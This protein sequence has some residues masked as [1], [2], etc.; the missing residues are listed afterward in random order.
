MIGGSHGAGIDRLPTGRSKGELIVLT[1][2][3]TRRF[4]PLDAAVSER[5]Q[6]ATSAELEQWADNILDA[7]RLE[8]V[9]GVG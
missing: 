7:R 6:K 8:E 3:L 1:R 9:F 4:G 2:L 5:L